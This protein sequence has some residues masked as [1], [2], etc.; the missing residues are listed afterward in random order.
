MKAVNPVKLDQPVD[1]RYKYKKGLFGKLKMVPTTVSEQRKLKKAFLQIFPDCLFVDDLFE[2][3]SV[4][5]EEQ[6]KA[7]AKANRRAFVEGVLVSEFVDAVYD[8][9]D[10]D[11]SGDDSDFAD[12]GD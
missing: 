7:R 5:T 11:Y 12:D 8:S 9:D 6:R 10:S 2:K 4:L 1:L 3:N